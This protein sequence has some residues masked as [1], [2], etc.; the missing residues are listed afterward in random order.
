[1]QTLDLLP[2]TRGRIE[3]GGHVPAVFPSILTFPRAGGKEM[4]AVPLECANVMWTDLDTSKSQAGI[5]YP[6]NWTA[7]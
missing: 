6:K 1:M 4:F 3:V 7:G 5:I 2:P